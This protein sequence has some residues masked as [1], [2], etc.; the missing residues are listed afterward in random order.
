MNVNAQSWRGRGAAQRDVR[1]RGLRERP[2]FE[3]AFYWAFVGGL[4]CLP[5]WYPKYAV[6]ASAVNG[7]WFCG[8]VISY[9]IL[10]MIR[11][12]SHAVGLQTLRAPAVLLIGV[13]IWIVIQYASWSPL[14]WQHPIWA[15][16]ASALESAVSGSVTI[17]PEMTISGLVRLVTAASVFWMA[18]QFCRETSRA[19]RFIEVLA[20]ICAGY[21]AFSLLGLAFHRTDV[22]NPLVHFVIPAL[23]DPHSYAVYAGIGLIIVAGLI[24][25]LYRYDLITVGGSL[26]FRI[27][28]V[29]EATGQKGALLVGAAVLM[30]VPFVLLDSRSGLI[31]TVFGLLVLLTASFVRPR[32][33]SRT[34]TRVTFF[35]L[36]IFGL[37]AAVWVHAID[38]YVGSIQVEGVE[39]ESRAAIAAIVL[40]SIM[41]S[42]WLGYGFGTFSDV[43]DITRDRSINTR[44]FWSSPFN[45]YLEVI[46]GLGVIAGTMLIAC[47]VLIA[48]KCLAGSMMRGRFSVVP[49][50]ATGVIFLVGV[51]AA[52]GSPLDVQAVSLLFMA[53]LGA[54]VAQSQDSSLAVHD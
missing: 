48:S 47:F 43:F 5:L 22:A 35:V 2:R 49:S 17:N 1:G 32:K 50:I 10:L 38:P 8:L 44:G 3:T 30:A 6:L 18:T 42:P 7:I 52:V 27:A 13:L 28:S 4:A 40:R 11:R 36:A 26:R 15:L 37:L 25:R 39:N 16:T 51:Q 19:Q 21:A 24:L 29:I 54:G 12:S 14:T 31:A 33:F 45:S 34:M 9:E 20:V 41:D 46:Q 53:I 23:S